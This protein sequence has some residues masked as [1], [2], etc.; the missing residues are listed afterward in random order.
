M[1]KFDCNWCSKCCEDFGEFITIERQMD[2]CDYYCR[3]GITDEIFPVHVQ[4]EYADDIEEE[5]MNM[6]PKAA[7]R[8]ARKGCIFSRKNP[9]HP[10]LACAIY[11]TRPTICREFKCYRMLIHH[12]TS[13]E[14][15]GRIIGINELRTHDEA[16]QA[17][18]EEKIAHLPHPIH[19]LNPDKKIIHGHEA[20]IHAH[21]NEIEHGEH[22]DDSD[23]VNNVVE[24]LAAHGYHG[25]PVE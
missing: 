2:D 24:V 6:D 20:H 14:L 8:P 16:L 5:F 1:A 18:W 9:Q 19:G 7:D 3:Y 4:P 15:R 21:L 23:W 22:G 25:D 17:I 10:G 13:P 12:K 11:D